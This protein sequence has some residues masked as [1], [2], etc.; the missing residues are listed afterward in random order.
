MERLKKLMISLFILANLMM[1]I[2]AQ[3]PK[4]APVI[5]FLYTPVTFI[6]NYL[7]LWRGWQMFAPNPSRIN[8]FI[9]ASI[10]FEDGTQMEWSFPR[11]QEGS[12]FERYMYG[13][14][15]RK[16]T[17]DAL[18]LNTMKF[19]WRDGAHFVLNKTEHMWNGKKP[20]FVI[21]RRRFLNIQDWSKKFVKHGE[22]IPKSK[23]KSYDFYKYK[24]P[25][26]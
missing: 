6:Q 22:E 21:L 2:R 18:R 26:K 1:M 12:L 15:Y 9:E 16:Y 7:S 5:N 25:S 23:Y 4:N 13:E 24:V 20:A 11:P 3:L 8:G 10:L 19:L 14:R 17:M